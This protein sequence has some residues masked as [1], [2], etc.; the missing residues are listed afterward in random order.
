MVFKCQIDSFLQEKK[1]SS[2]KDECVNGFNVVLEDTIL[3]PEGGG[4]PCDF[5]FMNDKPIID[6]QRKGIE[7]HHFVCDS[8]TQS[9]P[10]NVGDIVKCKIDWKRRHDH[11]QQ[12]SGQHLLSAILEREY[13]V[14][15]KSWW[16]GTELSFIEI[17]P[18]INLTAAQIANIENI[19]NELIATSTPVSVHTLTDKNEADIPAEITR[20][21]KGLPKDHVGDIRIIEIEGIDANM[22]CGTHVSNLAQLQC[23]KL[24]NLE[25]NKNR[26]FLNFLV[27]KRVLKRLQ[28]CIDREYEFNTILKGGPQWH[29]E[30]V[31]KIQINQKQNQKAL[32]LCLKELAVHEAARL[33]LINPQPKWYSL[34]RKDGIDTDFIST[35][36]KN[37]PEIK[38]ASNGLSLLFLTSA[39]ESGERGNMIL[40][41]DENV[42]ADLG[43]KLCEVLNGKGRGKGQRFQAKVNN[44]FKISAC[45]KL[46]DEYFNH[47]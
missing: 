17:D 13:N 1:S 39:E 23:I 4:Q 44:L 43:D 16:L 35:F 10:F 37:V 7:A 46:I 47:K 38:N 31:K 26:Q 15:T 34:H 19:C 24:L 41:G 9:P 6:V 25:K 28:E 18:K 2:G 22:C 3:F 45:E 20:A 29:I 42:V 30:L 14:A 36:L 8:E 40:Y 21:T 5:G 32:S 27:G 33:K 12:H 11:M